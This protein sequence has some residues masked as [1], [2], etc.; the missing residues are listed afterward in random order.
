[1]TNTLDYII[2]E[3][4]LLDGANYKEWRFTI[5]SIYQR[6]D[7]W[8]TISPPAT[9]AGMAS[10]TGNK[11][12]HK[13]FGLESESQVGKK[14]AEASVAHLELRRRQEERA[15]AHLRLAATREIPAR[16]KDMED[17]MVTWFYLEKEFK[18][19]PSRT[20]WLS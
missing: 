16:I 4:N 19:T 8:H 12:W 5:R 17:P 10:T 11:E 14:I 9:I 18:Q 15:M 2:S 7:L 6:E 3:K 20:K 1:M 13:E